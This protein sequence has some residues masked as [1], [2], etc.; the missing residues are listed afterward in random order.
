MD[1]FISL[2]KDLM[3]DNLVN[4][5]FK[6]IYLKNIE[7]FKKHHLNKIILLIFHY[8]NIIKISFKFL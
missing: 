3:M 2:I 8:Q 7:V 1:Y 4:K 5:N 6:L